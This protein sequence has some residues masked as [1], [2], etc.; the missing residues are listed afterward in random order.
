MFCGE[1]KVADQYVSQGHSSESQQKELLCGVCSVF[2]PTLA[3]GAGGGSH[4][5]P[6]VFSG[7]FLQSPLMAG[8]KPSP[9]SQVRC[10]S[11][12]H[13]SDT[14]WQKGLSQPQLKEVTELCKHLK[15]IYFVDILWSNLKIIAA[16]V[17]SAMLL[18]L[19]LQEVRCHLTVQD[20]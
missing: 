15:L 10:R 19:W 20:N 16:S 8:G 17:K 3:Q 11:A 1:I 6:M 18:A 7:L 4:I 5:L 9:L 12:R 2:I 14:T 13:P